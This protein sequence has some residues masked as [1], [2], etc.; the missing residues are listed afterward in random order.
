MPF[1][2]PRARPPLRA[3]A[4]GEEAFRAG[5]RQLLALGC[6]CCAAMALAPNPAA[7][8]SPLVQQHLAAARAAAGD[9]LRAY[10]RLGEVAAPTPGLRSASPAELRAM[11]TPPPGRAFDNLAFVGS[12]WVTAWAITTSDGIILVDAMDNDADAER[13][14]DAGMRQLGLD[15][16]QIRT[17]VVSHGHGDHYG[18]AGH[19]VRRYGSRVVCS[20]ADWTMMETGLEFDRPDWGRPPRRDLA[21]RDGDMIRLGDT[22]LEVMITPGHTMG[23]VTLLFDVRQGGR[24]HR[25]MMWGG[26][27]FNFGAR[28]DRI[29]RLQ[30]YIDATAR[31]REIA[32]RQNVEVFLSNHNVYDEAVEKL[33]R[34]RPGA[35]NPFVIGAAATQRALTVMHECARATMAAWSA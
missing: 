1:F 27:A 17:L 15:P 14:P 31:A 12:R 32:A 23:T 21:V 3:E 6:A 18:G 26:T 19:F 13:I 22:A 7:A 35:A 33:G 5:R 10:L 16:A 4:V 8:Q 2:K 20:E 30:G 24:T 9:D 28:A 29:P 34:M 25:A 11:A